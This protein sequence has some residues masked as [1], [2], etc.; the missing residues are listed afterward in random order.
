MEFLPTASDE[1][2]AWDPLTPLSRPIS[3]IPDAFND[4]DAAEI[5]AVLRQS[6]LEVQEQ[7]R[8][9]SVAE[10]SVPPRSRSSTPALTRATSSPETLDS[11]RMA[12]VRPAKSAMKPSSLK[13]VLKVS[14]TPLKSRRIQEDSSD[15]DD[16]VF[17]VTSTRAA[18]APAPPRKVAFAE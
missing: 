2:K 5:E 1:R 3:L 8:Q 18:P 12:A 14:A 13:K 16:H 7:S 6:R 10:G 11:T 9:S 15:D 17:V 4:E